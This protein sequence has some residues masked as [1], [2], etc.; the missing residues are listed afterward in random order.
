M[1]REVRRLLGN[2]RRDG[3]VAGQKALRLSGA[4]MAAYASA[5]VLLPE[6]DPVLAP[7]TALLVVQLTLTSTV[8]S[9]AQRVVSVVSGVAVAVFFSS[10]VGL[11][12]WSLGILIAVTVVIG[13]LLRLG[14]HLLEVPISAMLVLAVGGASS[15]A[16]ERILETLVGAAVGLG[17]NLLFPPPLGRGSVGAAVDALTRAMSTVLYTAGRE[18]PQDARAEAAELWLVDVRSLGR[19]LAEADRVLRETTERRRLNAR[20]AFTADPQ[21]L[22]SSGIDALEQ[23]ATAMRELFRSLA[24]GLR[25]DDPEVTGT[26]AREVFSVVLE[27]LGDCVR[28]FGALVRAE[29]QPGTEPPEEE[30]AAALEA[31]RESRARLVELLLTDASA[32]PGLWQSRGSLLAAVERVLQALDVE[33]RVRQRLAWQV[34]AARRPLRPAARR[35]VWRPL[36]DE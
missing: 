32:A 22:L 24:D 20:A 18:L 8:T 15:A 26:G 21:P 2:A 27:D 35:E 1:R 9:A 25:D 16:T 13:H 12:W 29:E 19:E 23:A 4:T 5:R 14:D 31:V 17:V 30:L 3:R 10:V 28:A 34:A 7:L 6:G 33:Q 11:A 36:D